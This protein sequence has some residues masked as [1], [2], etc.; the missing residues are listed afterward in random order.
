LPWLIIPGTRRYGGSR[1][2]NTRQYFA[3]LLCRSRGRG[4]F[5]ATAAVGMGN[6][7]LNELRNLRR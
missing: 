1:G 2:D 4:D 6:A 7:I 5:F 3:H